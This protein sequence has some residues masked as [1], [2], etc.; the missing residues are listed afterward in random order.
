MNNAIDSRAIDA[1]FAQPA[2]DGSFDGVFAD[3]LR[4]LGMRRP[5]LF[6]AFAPK[7]AGTF[8]RSAAIQ[9]VDG[10]LVRVVHAQGGRDAQPYLPIFIEYFLG[11]ICDGPL[12]THVHMQALDAN[13]RFLQA[14]GIRPIIM[15]RSITDM[16][17]SFWDMLSESAEARAEGLNCPIPDAFP[18]FSAAQKADFMIDMIAPWYVGYFATWLDYAREKPDEVCVLTYADFVADPAHVLETALDHADLSRS[19]FVCQAA[20]DGAWKDRSTLRYNKGA[21]GRGR[22]Y[23]SPA[24]LE[25]LSRMMRYHPILDGWRD[26]LL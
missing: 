7:A 23:F 6:F 20:L 10:Q 8:L 9:A 25:R 15:L 18:D 11:G 12:V 21:S 14:L 4:G 22:E 24:H 2:S 5:V 17:A 26:A 13:R 19:R 16:L 3:Y 1:A